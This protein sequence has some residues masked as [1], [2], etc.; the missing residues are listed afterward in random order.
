MIWEVGT[1]LKYI[2]LPPLGLAW[3]VVLA[4]L[5]LRNRPRMARWLLASALLFGYLLATPLVS[6]ALMRAVMVDTAQPAGVRPQAIVVLGGGRVL[7]LDGAGKVIEAYPS[8]Y[9]LERML[10]GA[11]LQKQT[12]LPLLVSGGSPDGRGWP[13]GGVMRDFMVRDF[14]VPVRWVED[15]SRNT[16]ENAAFS[17]ALLQAAGVRTVYL[18]THDFH[19]RRARLLF[20]AQGIRVV[21]FHAQ[22]PLLA[23]APPGPAAPVQFSV[24]ELIPTVN[25][26]STSFQACN[27]AAGLLYAVLR[28]R[29][30]A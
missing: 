23:Q 13:E 12:G 1:L 29:L 8:P 21:P 4:W 10:T 7:A 5:V 11:R 20:E 18:V 6:D 19:M 24:R 3:L 14:G 9:T 26:L 17:A 15:A 16:V 30:A 27:E 2:V 22:Q 25:G 28:I